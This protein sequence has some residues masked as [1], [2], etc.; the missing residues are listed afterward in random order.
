MP[1][2]EKDAAPV[3]P[4]VGGSM[5]LSAAVVVIGPAAESDKFRPYVFNRGGSHGQAKESGGEEDD[6][7]TQ[8]HAYCHQAEKDGEENLDDEARKTTRETGRHIHDALI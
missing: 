7:K 6:K 8:G 2:N 5:E 4:H 1:D 3:P